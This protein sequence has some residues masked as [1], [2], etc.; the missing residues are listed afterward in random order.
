MRN[1][2]MPYGYRIENGTVLI[3][4]EQANQVRKLCEGYLGGLGITSAAKEA[5]LE[6]THSAAMQMMLN[7]HYLGDDFY[8]AILDKETH[9]AVLAERESRAVSMNRKNRPKTHT[10]ARA[11]VTSFRMK[12]SER[13]FDN[14]Y[15]EVGYIYS[16]IE[17]EV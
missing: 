9:D 13:R 2:H 17:E 16:L 12:S 4:M 1:G 5:G 3:D 10:A 6:L 14:P 8:P 15:Q 7:V 11:P